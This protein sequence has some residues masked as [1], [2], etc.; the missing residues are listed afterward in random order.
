MDYLFM[1]GVFNRRGTETAQTG[2][3]QDRTGQDSRGQGQDRTDGEQGSERD[4]NEGRRNGAA[5]MDE[6]VVK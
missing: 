3:E 2:T 1:D 5:K 6:R 4:V